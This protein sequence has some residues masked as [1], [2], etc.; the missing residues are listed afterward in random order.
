MQNGHYTKD[1]QTAGAPAKKKE[2]KKV[3]RL[4]HSRT[5][6]QLGICENKTYNYCFF[7]YE[8]IYPI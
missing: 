7:S 1:L 2:K 4:T 3:K 5:L 6:S 8:A